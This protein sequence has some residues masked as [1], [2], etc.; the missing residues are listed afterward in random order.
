MR[1]GLSL[2]DS[3]RTPSLW[4]LRHGESWAFNLWTE[5]CGRDRAKSERRL[6]FLRIGFGKPSRYNL[7]PP[8]LGQYS[9]HEDSLWILIELVDYSRIRGGCH[10]SSWVLGL[11]A[12]YGRSYHRRPRQGYSIIRGVQAAS[13]HVPWL[14]WVHSLETWTP[15]GCRPDAPASP[16][17]PQSYLNS[18][19]HTPLRSSEVRPSRSA[20]IY[21]L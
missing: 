11:S 20:D 19:P 4:N 16:D 9:G 15:A 13:T 8:D 12:L 5:T 18:P 6:R 10:P 17:L 14:T 7:V 1:C 21:V 2:A 3:L